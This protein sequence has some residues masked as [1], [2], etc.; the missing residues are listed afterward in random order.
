MVKLL[1]VPK[2]NDDEIDTTKVNLILPIK[3]ENSTLNHSALHTLVDKNLQNCSEPA[4]IS[5]FCFF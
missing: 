4:R 5:I 2:D 1:D 3:E